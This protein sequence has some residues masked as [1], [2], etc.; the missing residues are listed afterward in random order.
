MKSQRGL[1][2]AKI[3]TKALVASHVDPLAQ[4]I[5]ELLH[6][7][8]VSPE[9][10]DARSW[11]VTAINVERSRGQSS[12]TP[13]QYNKPLVAVEE[14]AQRLA[15]AIRSLKGTRHAYWAFCRMWSRGPVHNN[16]FEGHDILPDLEA[17][18]RLPSKRAS[19]RPVAPAIFANSR[20]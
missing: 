1:A 13:A 17:M 2:A 5:E 20:S 19:G 9:N 12:P 14:A 3:P 15:A 10:A 16:Q 4:E 6:L 11:L 7:A 8:D 18:A